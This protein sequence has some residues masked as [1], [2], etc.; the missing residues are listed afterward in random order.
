MEDCISVPSNL[1][2]LFERKLWFPFLLK[3]FNFILEYHCM[4]YIVLVS[5]VQQNDSIIHIHVSI[6][7]EILFPFRLLQ[8]IEQSS[9]CYTVGSCW[10]SILKR[11]VCIY[12]SQTHNVSLATT[13]PLWQPFVFCLWVCCFCFVNKFICIIFFRFYI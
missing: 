10:L 8:N 5:G 7:F 1:L 9:L 11:V 6:L 12:S 13:F 2:L 3:F 4:E